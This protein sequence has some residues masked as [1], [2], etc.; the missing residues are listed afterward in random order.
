MSVRSLSRVW[1]ATLVLFAVVVAG[2]A[3]C[4]GPAESG[5]SPSA[6]IS[7]ENSTNS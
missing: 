5:G 1:L 7:D 2:S 3:G 4:T 6:P